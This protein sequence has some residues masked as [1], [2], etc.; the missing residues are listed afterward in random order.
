MAVFIF[1]G[2]IEPKDTE[3]GIGLRAEFQR[4]GPRRGIS[5]MHVATTRDAAG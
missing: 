4:K 3:G 1:G 2:V 5:R